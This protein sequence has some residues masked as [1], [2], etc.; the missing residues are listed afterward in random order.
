VTDRIAQLDNHQLV[1]AIRQ[2]AKQLGFDLVGI[3]PAAPSAYREYLRQWLDDGQHG[4]MKWLEGRFDERTDLTKYMPGAKS[5]ICVAMNYYAPIDDLP[6]EERKDHGRIARYALGHDYHELIKSKLYHLADWIRR[7]QPSAETRCGVDTAPIME[8]ELAARAGIG[9][10]GKNCCIINSQI[11]S[12]LLLGEIVTNLDLPHDDPAT[13]RCGTCRRCIDAC[14]TGAIT[15][16]YQLDARKCISYL[17]I[18]H[19]GEIDPALQPQIGEW[20]FGC[21]I[22]QDVCPWNSKAPFTT[23]PGFAPRFKTATLDLDEVKRWEGE[24]YAARLKGSAMKRVKLPIL[25]RNARLVK[26]NLTR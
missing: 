20:L 15:A 14:P 24:Q 9:W 8:K 22:C 3:A 16:P 18:E 17:T 21:D 12:W 7:T 6:D 2:E 26:E 23:E 11:G 13:D 1:A 10:L 25:K 4:T 19:R 5:V